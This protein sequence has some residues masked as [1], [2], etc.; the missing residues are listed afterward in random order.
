MTD[1]QRTRFYFPA[2]N[3]CARANNW[4]MAKG[5]LTAEEPHGDIL[6]PELAQ[7]WNCARQLADQ[8]H[9]G[10]TPRDLRYGCH[11]VAIQ[12]P[13][14]SESLTNSEVNRVVDL[15]NR[16]ADTN[17]ESLQA[18]S[19]WAD[20]TIAQRQSLIA[21]IE[22]LSPHAYVAEISFDQCGT[23]DWKSVSIESLQCFLRTVKNRNPKRTFE[24]QRRR[25]VEQ[26]SFSKLEYVK[27]PAPDLALT[28]ENE[29]F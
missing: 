21:A 6:I 26:K 12:R 9:R 24:P 29:P 10:I 19:R 7:V 16:L 11:I 20:P 22:K 25:D 28:N 8:E 1:D 27:Q 13:K 17:S 15:F 3:R 18:A 4:R 14:R 2:W 5:R 23:R